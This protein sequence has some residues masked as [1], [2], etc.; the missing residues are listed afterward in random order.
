MPLFLDQ[1]DLTFHN[2][3]LGKMAL[4]VCGD[5]RQCLFDIHTTCKP[6]I[7]KATKKAM[8]S[9]IVITNT[10]EKRGKQIF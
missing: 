2:A 3:T 9:L 8:E 4:D 7:G 1:T 6:S 5:N 10:L